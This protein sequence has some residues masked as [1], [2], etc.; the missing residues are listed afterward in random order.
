[1]SQSVNLNQNKFMSQANEA[2]SG[3]GRY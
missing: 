3:T 1:M 2:R